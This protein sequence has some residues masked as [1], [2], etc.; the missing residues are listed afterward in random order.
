MQHLAR[1]PDDDRN[2]QREIGRRDLQGPQPRLLLGQAHARNHARGAR[3]AL[4]I[5][6][7]V[8]LGQLRVQIGV[9]DKPPLLEERPFDPAH[10]VFDGSLLLRTPGP[11]HLDAEAEVERHA[12]EE[13]I[14]FR[15]LAITRPLDGHH[16]RAIED[17][18]EG[19]PAQRGEVIHQRAHERLGALV[20]HDRHRDP[21]G[22]FQSGGE[23]VHALLRTIEER[24]STCPE[25]C[26]VNSPG[27]PSNRTTGLTVVGRIAAIKS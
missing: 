17:G 2:A 12:G 21:A 7:D 14:P 20:R 16:R 8:P 25:S 13:G 26:C 18:Q 11:A 23:E 6:L 22:V 15:H 5:H 4:R 3:G 9:V 19:D 1:R 24:T 27:S 10:E